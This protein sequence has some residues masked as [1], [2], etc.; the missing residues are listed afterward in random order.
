MS[1]LFINADTLEYPRYPGDVELEPTVNWAE[2]TTTEPPIP[3]TNM[4]VVEDTP[5]LIGGIWKQAWKQVPFIQGADLL[6][7]KWSGDYTEEEIADGALDSER[8]ILGLSQ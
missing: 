3:E 6:T 1:N 4:L 2:V 7:R 8:R 5:V